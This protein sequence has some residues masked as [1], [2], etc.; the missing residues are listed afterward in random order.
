[1]QIQ[2]HLF[3]G[4]AVVQYLF[5]TSLGFLPN[6][7]RPDISAQPVSSAHR[8]VLWSIIINPKIQKNPFTGGVGSQIARLGLLRLC[9]SNSF[10]KNE[11][12]SH[13]TPHEV[14]NQDACFLCQDQII[15]EKAS[16]LSL[17]LAKQ[18]E[19]PLISPSEWMTRR[20]YKFALRLVPYAYGNGNDDDKEGYTTFALAIDVLPPE[21]KKARSSV[22][23]GKSLGD[24]AFFVELCPPTGS[25]AGRRVAIASGSGDLLLKAVA[26]GK[27]N[28]LLGKE[29]GATIVDLTAGLGQD[30]LVLA[31]NGAKHVHMVERNP[32]VA[33]M[34]TDALRR[35]TMLAELPLSNYASLE[36][37]Q[38][39]ELANILKSKLTFSAMD[40]K[41]WLLE[42]R[43]PLQNTIVYL[44]PMFPPRRKSAAV[45]KGMAMLHDLLDSRSTNE[46]QR[47]LEEADLLQLAWELT[48]LRVVVKR[49]VN[50]PPLGDQELSSVDKEKTKS[51]DNS[52]REK[53]PRRPSYSIKGSINRWDVYV[54][55]G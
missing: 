28:V 24:S 50:A 25:K 14:K 31:M 22:N 20:K 8:K 36:W 30:S 18:L 48:D 6:A 7:V 42:T 27:G 39:H 1:M 45:K 33:A 34:L 53:I 49:P 55:S 35:L 52:A 29:K 40:S 47:L 12:E 16:E 51:G 26:P 23:K 32:F 15:I 4:L 19:L 11:D 38:R 3:L 21:T 46:G 13:T 37:K 9:T 2:L 17:G 41:E 54:K 43:R 5:R 44:D 10:D